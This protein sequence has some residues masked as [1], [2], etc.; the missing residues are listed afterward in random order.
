[1]AR[2][3]VTWHQAKERL[4]DDGG[5]G[6]AALIQLSAMLWIC[7]SLLNGLTDG[8]P[9]CVRQ[10]ARSAGPLAVLAAPVF[11]R[12]R[13]TTVQI[14]IIESPIL[15]LSYSGHVM[16]FFLKCLTTTKKQ[17]QVSQLANVT[18]LPE[19]GSP[20][21]NSQD[22][23]ILSYRSIFLPNNQEV[24]YTWPVAG[25]QESTGSVL[26][27]GLLRGGTERGGAMGHGSRVF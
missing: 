24:T 11:Y 20:R 19:P 3:N 1:M 6:V 22:P 13:P 21:R 23:F 17:K 16:D 10:Q 26:G 25:S 4:E 15:S 18:L 14:S 5:R 27:R 8:T 9:G 2:A 7:R 12:V